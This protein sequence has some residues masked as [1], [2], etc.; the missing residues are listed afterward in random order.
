MLNCLLDDLT[1][2]INKANPA[3]A[4]KVLSSVGFVN[5]AQMCKGTERVMA[6]TNNL[7]IVPHGNNW[8]VRREE[9][10]RVSKTFETQREAIEWSRGQSPHEVLIHNLEGRIRERSTYGKDP[11]PPKG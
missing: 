4:P 2:Y 5:C 6:N 8:A 11:Y 7:H 1:V 3:D 10:G 9:A